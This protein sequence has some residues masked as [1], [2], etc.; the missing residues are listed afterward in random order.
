MSHTKHQ[1]CQYIRSYQVSSLP[2]P[3]SHYVDLYTDKAVATSSCPRPPPPLS[4]TY[5]MFGAPLSAAED[6]TVVQSL[7]SQ[8]IKRLYSAKDVDRK[9]EL[10]KLNQSVLVNF[11]DLLDILIRAP[12]SNKREEKV[13]NQALLCKERTKSK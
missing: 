1:S 3:P 13:R 2:L 12:E 9:R 8:G 7:E 10:H 11:L 5:S 4:D 6:A